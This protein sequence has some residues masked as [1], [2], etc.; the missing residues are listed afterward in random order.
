MDR[1]CYSFEQTNIEYEC[2][3]ILTRKRKDQTTSNVPI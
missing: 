2:F 3:D 1:I